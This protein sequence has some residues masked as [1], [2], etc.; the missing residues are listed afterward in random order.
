MVYFILLDVA[1]VTTAAALIMLFMVCVA[2]LGVAISIYR[3][4]FGISQQTLSDASSDNITSETLHHVCFLLRSWADSIGRQSSNRKLLYRMVVTGR[5]DDALASLKSASH[6]DNEQNVFYRSFDSIFLSIYPDFVM[7]VNE[8]L[9]GA[10]K[11]ADHHLSAEMRIIALM[12]LG[13]ENTGDI[14]AMLRY[15]PQTV[16]NLRSSIRSKMTVEKDEFYHRLD[17]IMPVVRS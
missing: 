8:M 16:Y 15:S 12:K 1:A 17:L 3:I 6:I 4:T 7:Q 13:I 5:Y 11:S 14:S 9:T 2:I 10:A